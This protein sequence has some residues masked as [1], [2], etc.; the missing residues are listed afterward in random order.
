MPALLAPGI[1]S[2]MVS[3]DL[4]VSYLA[5]VR[6]EARAQQLRPAVGENVTTGAF[7][8]QPG[9]GLEAWSPALQLDLAYAPRFTH[10]GGDGPDADTWL[11]RAR[12]GVRWRPTSTWELLTSG[13]AT[14]GSVDLFR[15][16]TAPGPGGEVPAVGQAAPVASYLDYRRFELTLAAEGRLDHRLEL[17]TRLAL[18]REGGAGT[19]EREIL[20]LQ[21]SAQLRCELAWLLSPPSTLAGVLSAGETHS[22]DVAL[23]DPVTGAPTHQSW[24][25]RVARLEAVWRWQVNKRTRAWAGAGSA[26][27]DSGAPAA[28]RAALKPIGEVGLEHASAPGWPQLRGWVVAAA[29]PI[30]DRVIGVVGQRAELRGWGAWSPSEHWSLGVS[31]MGARVMDG[32]T[33]RE[34]FTAGEFWITRAVRDVMWLSAGGRWTTR[35]PAPVLGRSGLPESQW[36]VY[37]SAQAAYRSVQRQPDEGQ[38]EAAGRPAAARRPAPV[39]PW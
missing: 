31:A 7:E 10:Q 27:V 5:G 8:L 6:A 23:A 29:A 13:T 12:A 25:T 19:A 21:Q 16:A 15:I 3:A 17:R 1:L 20:P 30:E 24:S 11:H 9:A 35:W 4:A 39:V 28:R 36:V 32:P 22:F 14:A 26:L 37:L 18:L 34:A 33:E 2:L 38:P